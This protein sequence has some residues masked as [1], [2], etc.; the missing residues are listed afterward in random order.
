MSITQRLDDV[1]IKITLAGEQ[2]E[3]AMHDLKLA[4]DRPTWQ[5]YFWE[6]VSQAV[7]G[8]PLL[9][10]GLILRARH[11]PD[12]PDDTTVKLRPSRR[13]QFS[14]EWLA[15]Q[16]VGDREL[17]VEADWAGNRHKLAVSYTADRPAGVA[18]GAGA[19]AH[20][21]ASVF[22]ETQ[23]VFL[24]ECLGYSVNL[25]E[26][27]RLPPITAMRWK[28]TAAPDILKVRAERWTV[29]HLDFLELS[30][31]ASADDAPAKQRTLTEF[32]QSL[33][34]TIKDDQE[35]KTEQVL[36]HLVETAIAA[37]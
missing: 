32:V 26:L 5:I 23:L 20:S 2:I 9:D 28:K 22:H 30:I 27:T 17:K 36:L 37:D 19:D 31:V 14:A 12:D 3:R 21:V 16:K 7:G 33:D 15:F 8:T 18:G 10:L 13:S 25:A 1:E 35:S 24:R 6:D 11:K 29:D 34:L 4:T